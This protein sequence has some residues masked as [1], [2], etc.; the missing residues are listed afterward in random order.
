MA[1]THV[2]KKY[3][4]LYSASAMRELLYRIE[5]SSKKPH[6]TNQPQK[7]GQNRF[8]KTQKGQLKS[9]ATWDTPLLCLDESTNKIALNIKH[10]W[11]LTENNITTPI[12]YTREKFQSFGA[13]GNKGVFFCGFHDKSNTDSF[14]DFIKSLQKQ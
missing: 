9:T 10:G 7:R 12:N 13:L 5:F 11:Y 4:T 2:D 6:I 3:N 8:K 14:L 1:I